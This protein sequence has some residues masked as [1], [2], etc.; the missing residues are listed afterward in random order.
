M[1][2]ARL[3]FSLASIGQTSGRIN[4]RRYEHTF[5]VDMNYAIEERRE[6]VAIWQTVLHGVTIFLVEAD[7]FAAKRGVYTYTEEDER[8]VAWQHRGSGHFDYFAMNI[9]LQKAA[10]DLMIL[11][12]DHPDVIHCQDGHAATLPAMMRENSG[13][14]H[15]FRQTGAV[16]TIHNAGV[17]YHQEVGDF[18]FAQAITGLPERVI[19]SGLLAGNFDPFIAA[20]KYAVLNTVSEN[21]GRELQQTPDDARTGGLGHALLEHGVILAGIT[22][23]I[24]PASF[25]PTRPEKLGLAAGYD[26]LGGKLDGKQK[27]K[28]AMLAQITG[29]GPWDQVKQFGTLAPISE[30]PLFTFIGRLT[31]QKGIDVLIETIIEVLPQ[32]LSAQFLILGYGESEFEQQ[33]ELLATSGIG[34]GRICFLRG[35][36][37]WLANKVYAAGDFLL[38]PSRYEPCGLTDYIAQLLGNLPIVHRV[39]G[40][41]KVVDGQTGFSYTGNTAI[42]LTAAVSRALALYQQ[43]PDKIRV[44]QRTAVEQIIDYHTWEKVMDAYLLLYQQ[45]IQM[46]CPPDS[47]W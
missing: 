11:L 26:V 12:D 38:I 20:A 46:A 8:E 30:R 9:L 2:A 41:V 5:E 37:S 40:L 17:G 4:G 27:C 21:Y 6:V 39:G 31:T 10:L 16:V 35:Y 45:A 23:G 44:M 34:Q 14:R 15:Y 3:G 1:D 36:D 18:E 43:D 47:T 13:Y 7:R 22:N 42:A 24:D 19:M 25:D 28:A 33:L 29:N 32:E